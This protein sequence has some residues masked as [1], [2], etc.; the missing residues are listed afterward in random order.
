MTQTS[1]VSTLIGG[2]WAVP[3]A[4]AY[5]DVHNPSTGETIARTPM[6]GAAE[7]DAAVQAAKRAFPA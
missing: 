2:K 3:R 5:T 6:C 1:E 4:T 7:V